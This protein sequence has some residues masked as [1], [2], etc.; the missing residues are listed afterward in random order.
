MWAVIGGRGSL[1]GQLAW[2]DPEGQE[3]DWLSWAGSGQGL[4]V[5]RP[6]SAV[7][8]GTGKRSPFPPGPGLSLLTHRP[9]SWSSPQEARLTLTFGK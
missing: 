3:A 1:G 5:Q 4:G 2:G 8:S 9:L 6:Q 7:V